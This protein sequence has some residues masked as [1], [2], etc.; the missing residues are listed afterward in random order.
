MAVEGPFLL[1][2]QTKTESRKEALKVLRAT[3][4]R[5][6]AE[7]PGKDELI[8]SKKNITGGFALNIDSNSDILGYISMIGFYDLPLD[9]LDTFIDKVNA[10]TVEQIHDAFIRRIHPDRMTLITVGS[11]G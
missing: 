6:L 7:G 10:V 9:Y 5:F 4:K 8:A 11:Q 2:L 1:S 3:L